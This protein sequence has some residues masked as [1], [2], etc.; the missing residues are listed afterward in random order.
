MTIPLGPPLLHRVATGD[1]ASVRECIDRFGGLVWSIARRLSPSPAE[2][3]DAVQ[4]IFVDLWRSAARFDPR[5]SSDT[6]F[7]A[8]IA[9]RRLLDRRR[10]RQRRPDTEPFP[11]VQVGPELAAHASQ[12]LCGEA[13]L[14]A[15]ALAQLRPEQRQVLLLS[16]CHGLSHDEIAT[17]T[18]MP[19]GTVKAHARRGLL[20]V[21]ELLDGAPSSTVEGRP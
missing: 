15:K 9:R 3:E 20:R 10:R 11:D 4:D 18:G 19:L 1:P 21:R 6:A 13:A 17:L 12:E 16:A 14:A 7:V 5:I 8:V 2:A